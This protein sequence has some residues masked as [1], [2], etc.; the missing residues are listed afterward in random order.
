MVV[1]SE[2]AVATQLIANK[3]LPTDEWAP[4]G[5]STELNALLKCMNVTME[6]I[7]AAKSKIVDNVDMSA[8]LRAGTGECVKRLTRGAKKVSNIDTIYA[9]LKNFAVVP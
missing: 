4:N 2:N 1:A 9:I 5:D 7:E 6:S 3:A 8:L